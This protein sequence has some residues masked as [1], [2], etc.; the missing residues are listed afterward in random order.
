MADAPKKRRPRNL[1]AVD[2]E[3]LESLLH[4]RGWQLTRQRLEHELSMQQ[5]DLERE[6]TE[7]ETAHIRGMIGG[8]RLAIALP[9]RIEKEAR[10][11]G[12][13]E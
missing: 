13:I 11:K 6:H 1:D 5:T 2:G 8:L 9:E 10:S 4:S 7:T 3:L 12:G